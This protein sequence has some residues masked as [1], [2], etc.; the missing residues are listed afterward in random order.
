[1]IQKKIHGLLD[2]I[3]EEAQKS[4]GIMMDGGVMSL[5]LA[6]QPNHTILLTISSGHVDS[7]DMIRNAGKMMTDRILSDIH[8]AGSNVIKE[9]AGDAIKSA[10]FVPAEKSEEQIK[11]KLKKTA[12]TA[13]RPDDCH[14]PFCINA[15]K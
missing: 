15:G 2:V 14:L 9:D 5:Q 3:L 4:I 1:M 12:K 13:G 10:P 7:S 8:D 11:N 6:P